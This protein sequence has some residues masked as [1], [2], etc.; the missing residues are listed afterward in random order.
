MTLNIFRTS[1][2][3]FEYVIADWE[4][5][6]SKLFAFIM[7]NLLHQILNFFPVG[8]PLNLW[9]STTYF[10][11]QTAP[12]YKESTVKLSVLQN[13]LIICKDMISL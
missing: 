10:S 5:Y 7:E 11:N 4:P 12:A 9:P 1:I 8:F 2:V 13:Q 3:N 6:D